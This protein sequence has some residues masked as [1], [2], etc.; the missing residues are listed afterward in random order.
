MAK[1]TLKG[2]PINLKGP[3]LKVGDKAPDFQ[4]QG[5][6]M[7]EISLAGG[8]GKTRILCSVP[9]L[10]TPVCS[11]ETKKFNEKATRNPDV[12][13][14]VISTDLPFAMMRWCGAEGV[15]R[16]RCASDHRDATFGER[17]GVLITD[18]PLARCL[19]RAV[20]VVGPDG[21]LKHVEYVPEIASEPNYDAALAAAIG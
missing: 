2:S 1:V 15:D 6:D 8:Q 3:E 18:G 4:L 20:F 12:E 7:S 10:D 9:S 17:Y 16:V 5:A 11:I 21:R 19:A 13:V 14:I